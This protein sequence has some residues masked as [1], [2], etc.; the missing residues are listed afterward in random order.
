MDRKAAPN[1]RGAKVAAQSVVRSLSP[2]Q[3]SAAGGR[4]PAKAERR[5]ARDHVNPLIVNTVETEVIPRLLLAAR[6]A[7]GGGKVSVAAESGGDT[8]AGML[9]SGQVDEARAFVKS[10]RQTGTTS[11][12]IY[13]DLLAPAARRMGEM[14]DEDVCHF[15]DV[16]AALMWLHRLMR[17]LEP[18]FLAR[19][20]AERAGHRALL[21]PLPGEQHGF[22]LAM[23]IS[24]FRQG[25]WDVSSGSN[26]G[27]DG[28]A[29]LVRREWFG[30][31]GFSVA[32]LDRM[33]LLA[34]EIRAVRRASRNPRIGVMVGG[35]AFS[36]QPGLAALVGA[37]ATAADGKQAVAQAETL[38]LALGSGSHPSG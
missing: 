9:L 4:E 24:F 15:A 30:V 18:T 34:S 36:A 6:A 38:L 23:V 5:P 2:E 29:D 10:M 16:T 28:L 35:P 14:W 25:G 31:I 33:E 37:D 27:G 26:A 8:L 12:A 20:G 11:E 32:R 21:V 19:R 22:G 17:E 13:L 3:P 7:A 1:G